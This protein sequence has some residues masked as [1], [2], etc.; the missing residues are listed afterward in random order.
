L[1]IPDNYNF[2]SICSRYCRSNCIIHCTR[3][4]YYLYTSIIFLLHYMECRRGLAMSILSICS[5]VRPS[6]CQTRHLWQNE[7]KNYC[8]HFIPYERSLSRVFW[9]E[10]WLV[11]RHLY[12]CVRL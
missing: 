9:E 12:K 10:E 3:M 1:H 7:R 6:V 11:G 5:S 4:T 2:F 8:P